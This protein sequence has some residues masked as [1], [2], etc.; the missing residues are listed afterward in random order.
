MSESQT[1]IDAA[2]Q[3]LQQGDQRAADVL[4]PLVYDELRRIASKLLD[5]ESPGHTLQT[6]ALVNE[7]YLKL[8]GQR[9]EDFR[10]RTHF[11]AVG[12]QA[13]RRILVDHARGR[14]RGK[15]GAGW[16]RLGLHEESAISPGRDL[17]VLALDEALTRLETLHP[18][19]ARVV[20]LRCYGGLTIEE[21]AEALGV[22]HG[23]VE[24]DWRL[25][26]AWLRR[27]LEG[28]EP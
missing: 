17:D 15:R 5:H 3:R 14:G 6:T 12:A 28:D 19:V 22:S 24:Q 21:T 23:T 11:L 27:E 1:T 9:K 18:R 26:R 4:F 2:L 13:M 25:A 8:Q 16:T 7:A 20:V 10:G